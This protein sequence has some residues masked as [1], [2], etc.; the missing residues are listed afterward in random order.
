LSPSS[1]IIAGPTEAPAQ[2]RVRVADF[3][4]AYVAENADREPTQEEYGQL[5][6]LTM[7]YFNTF[8]EKKYGNSTEIMFLGAEPVLSFTLFKAGIPNDRFNIY[9][10]YE[11]VDVIF[12]AES[13]PPS[14]AELFVILRDSISPE[15]ILDYV[16]LASGTPFVSTNEVV[17][18]ASTMDGP[19]DKSAQRGPRSG[20]S[21][22]TGSSS[23]PIT[24]LAATSVAALLILVA[25]VVFYR[26]RSWNENKYPAEYTDGL[27]AMD[28]KMIEGYFS[29][30]S[31]TEMSESQY[32]SRFP[33]LQRVAEEGNSTEDDPLKRQGSY[34][35]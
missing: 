11:Y 10:D 21:T 6:N 26:K 28:S 7:E 25:G 1:Q 31:V 30:N 23:G 20:D 35:D 12:T 8:L 34:R 24:A 33:P 4:L 22:T 32:S 29:E 14:A 13:N 5:V 3:Y 15:Y 17:F 2:K 19:T 9:M 18:R 27:Y 16:R